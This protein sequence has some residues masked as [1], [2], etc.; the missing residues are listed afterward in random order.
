[1]SA[2]KLVKNKQ[3]PKVKTILANP[4]KIVCPTLTDD[5]F[6]CFRKLLSDVVRKS[7][8][9]PLEYATE[10]H[11]KIGLE[12]SLRAI[13]NKQCSC[14]LISHSIKPRYLIGLITRNVEVHNDTAPVFVQVQLEEFILDLFGIKAL[15]LVLPKDI[16]EVCEKLGSW[17]NAHKRLRKVKTIEEPKLI[18]KVRSK[19]NSNVHINS[20]E[21]ISQIDITPVSM[22][23][24][25]TQNTLSEDFIS[26]S[27]PKANFK[28]DKL[29]L[30][31]DKDNLANA[32]SKI[33]H[34]KDHSTAAADL[35]NDASETERSSGSFST[36]SSSTST[37]TFSSSELE[38][39]V[40]EFLGNYQPLT[41]HKI[42]PNPKRLNKKKL[43]KN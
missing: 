25:Q 7:E 28:F 30:N 10:V 4:Y 24:Q 5:D 36:S 39:E 18:K 22:E 21:S 38:S 23:V 42:I 13:N 19:N 27:N 11:I 31:E 17:I 29:E 40:D 14:V 1:M 34:I 15:S 8:K 9:Q 35:K 12:S 26:L 43:K 16:R 32:L 41:V 2:T 37:N 6:N 20:K 3:K 33:A